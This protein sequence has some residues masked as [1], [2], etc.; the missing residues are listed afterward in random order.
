MRDPLHAVALRARLAESLAEVLE[1]ALSGGKQ[2]LGDFSICEHALERNYLA[3][4]VSAA[5]EP[6]ADVR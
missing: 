3:D 5:A 1:S 6:R 2:A 4:R